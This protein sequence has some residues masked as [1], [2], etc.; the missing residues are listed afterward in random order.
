[1]CFFEEHK[2]N[3]T[4]IR[5][6]QK[7]FLDQTMRFYSQVQ[8]LRALTKLRAGVLNLFPPIPHFLVGCC[9][10]K[11]RA[12]CAQCF[13]PWQQP[14]IEIMLAISLTIACSRC[15]YDGVILH[16]H[17]VRGESHN[18]R[19]TTGEFATTSPPF[20][21]EPHRS[22]VLCVKAEL[23]TTFT[24]WSQHHFVDVSLTL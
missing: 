2:S 12:A 3:Y 7:C 9:D 5:F 6:T 24:S 15:T 18:Q 8:N 22:H 20:Y 14:T 17:P 13:T 23:G 21:N 19:K 11:S 1:V 16:A 10:Q 4:F